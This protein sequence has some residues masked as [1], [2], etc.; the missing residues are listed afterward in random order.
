MFKKIIISFLLLIFSYGVYAMSEKACLF[1]GMS[2]VVNYKGKPA[3]NVRL[4]RKIEGKD[5]DETVTD[6]NGYFEFSPIYQKKSLLRL[7][8]TEFVIKQDI[9]AFTGSD[10]IN[11]WDGVKRSKE[12][13]AESRGKPLVVKC[14]LTQ[15]KQKLVI[16]NEGPIFSLC[17]WDVEADEERVIDSIFDE[18]EK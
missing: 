15:E 4:L 13:N 3:V 1:S 10:E 8:P 7:L 6:E 2:G 14:E 12:E 17:T 11:I 16:V 9:I 5:E 18:P